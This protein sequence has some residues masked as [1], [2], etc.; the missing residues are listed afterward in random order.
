MG[1]N[2]QG[3]HHT[4]PRYRTSF[5]LFQ[6]STRFWSVKLKRGEFNENYFPAKILMQNISICPWQNKLYHVPFSHL[7]HDYSGFQPQLLFSPLTMHALLVTKATV[8]SSALSILM[9]YALMCVCLLHEHPATL[10]A[11][12]FLLFLFTLLLPLLCQ[13][14]DNRCF[15]SQN[16][17]IL[18]LQILFT[19][20]C[21]C[22]VPVSLRGEAEVVGERFYLVS[23]SQVFILR[24]GMSHW[25][26]RDG[27][28]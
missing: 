6:T 21:L 3:V 26:W 7:T 10:L 23:H 24:K 12:W 11:C 25:G 2:Y 13:G 16:A 8:L 18:E 17:R 14:Y 9:I 4:N 19:E 27:I 5:L 1:S 15:W 20:T 28:K 22:V